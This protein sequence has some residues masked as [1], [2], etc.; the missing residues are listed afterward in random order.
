MN[1]ISVSINAKL[2]GKL[3]KLAK[4]QN[5]SFDEIV[6][7]ALAEYVDTVNDNFKTDLSSVSSAER[8]FFLSIGK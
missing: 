8:S 6:E 3:L 1:N 4:E 7:I 5:C 2:K